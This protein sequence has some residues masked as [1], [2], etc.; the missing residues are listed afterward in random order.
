MKKIILTICILLFLPNFVFAQEPQEQV[1]E[2]EVIEVIAEQSVVRDDGTEILQQDLKLKALEG[3]LEGQEILTQGISDLEVVKAVKVKP[4]QRVIVTAS[5]TPEGEQIFYIT[6]HVRRGWLYFLTLVFALLLIIIGRWK[7]VKAIISLIITFLIIIG[8]IVPRILAGGSPLLNSI[9]GSI[10]I[11]AAIVYITWG[12]NRKAHIAA[13]SI[14][15]SLIVTGVISILFTK[16]TQLSGSA[17]DDVMFLIGVGEQAINFQGLLLAGIIIGTLGVL[18]DVVISQIS[19]IEQ[20]KKANKHLTHG[21]LVERGLSV[22]I[23]HISSMT[24]TLFLAYAGVSLP[25]LLLF[26]SGDSQLISFSQ[27]I[28]NEVI[29]TEI[30]RTLTGS[31]GLI[32]AVP[33]STVIAAHWLVKKSRE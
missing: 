19:A 24:N 15:L 11:L 9:L 14:L 20:I 3:E 6:D 18:D 5:T 25:L 1:F 27:A 28:N 10:V 29:A 16:L 12:F 22:G 30:V 4:G 31:I 26:V 13:I 2:A 7:G 32:L 33:L 17:Q 8:F 23:D 21:E